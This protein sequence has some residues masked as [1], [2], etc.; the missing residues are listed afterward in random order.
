M[1]GERRLGGPVC[2]S[3]VHGGL[4]ADLA[5]ARQRI[6]DLETEVARL[7]PPAPVKRRVMTVRMPV[8]LIERIDRECDRRKNRSREQVIRDL[9]GEALELSADARAVGSRAGQ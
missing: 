6:A 2:T 8:D 4:E 9:C 7:Q 1:I 5:A 3:L